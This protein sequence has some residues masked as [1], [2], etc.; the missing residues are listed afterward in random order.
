MRL[1]VVVLA[2]ED[3]TPHPGVVFGVFNGICGESSSKK[4]VRLDEIV[5]AILVVSFFLWA[6]WM[7]SNNIEPI[8]EKISIYDV[9]SDTAKEVDKMYKT[10]KEWRRLLAPERYS[11]T[12]QGGTEKAFTGDYYNLK[13]EG[14]YKCVCCG[15][16]LFGSDTKFDSGSGWPS[17]WA[18]VSELNIRTRIDNR[19]SME[20]IEALCA[21]CEAH[22]G[23]VFDDGPPPSYKRYCINSAAMKFV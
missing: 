23:H 2:G 7:K 8:K 21:R 15:T 16:D 14:I 5:N 19:L 17:F 6:G 18:P 13:E 1:R 20:R 4:R 3:Q 12:R 11:I 22:L 9:R 10:D